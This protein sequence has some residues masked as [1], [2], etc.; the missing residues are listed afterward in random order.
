MD[1]NCEEMGAA[2]SDSICQRLE[3]DLFATLEA[4]ADA[5]A[6][7]VFV[8]GAPRTGSTY[9]Y[10]LC[11]HRWG[12]PYLDNLTNEKLWRWPI[13]GVL[14]QWLNRSNRRIQF[15]SAYG[16]T[17]GPDQPSEGSNTMQ[18]WFGGGHPS[19]VVS[20]ETLP[21]REPHLLQTLDA[22]RRLTGQGLLIKN[23]WNC[24]RVRALATRLSNALFLWIRRDI[25]AA[26]A[27]DLLARYR[28]Q[29][30]PGRWNSATPANLA[31]L[32]RRHPVEQVIENQFEF[33]RAIDSALRAHAQG[34]FATVWYEDLLA[35]PRACL[36][37]IEHSLLQL[38]CAARHTLPDAAEPRV[39]RQEK[40]PVG[41][42]PLFEEYLRCNEARLRACRYG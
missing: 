9:L 12:L 35:D 28:V 23:A 22:V 5:R 25:A 40:L 6:P 31:Q 2:N 20:A 24:F 38:R 39:A 7:A 36:E 37:S 14:Y 11:A 32:E 27:S 18:W 41:D 10:Q 42:L 3:I 1:E 33:H 13:V 30:S 4:E 29:G 8:L 16:K 26:S 19:Q 15:E 17:N 21:R 34:R